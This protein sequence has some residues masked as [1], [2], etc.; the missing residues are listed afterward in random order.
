MILWQNLSTH[1]STTAVR[2]SGIPP[3]QNFTCSVHSFLMQN[4]PR[5]ENTNEYPY[6]CLTN[7]QLPLMIQRDARYQN[8]SAENHRKECNQ[9]WL[10]LSHAGIF[11]LNVRTPASAK[12]NWMVWPWTQTVFTT[13]SDRTEG[14]FYGFRQTKMKWNGNPKRGKY[15]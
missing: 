8:Q 11:T 6:S 5:P 15:Y 12:V 13:A 14:K 9:Y 2:S 7:R 10:R 1:A 4:F 3:T